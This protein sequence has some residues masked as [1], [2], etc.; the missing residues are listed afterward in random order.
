[1]P[2]SIHSVK[3]QGFELKVGRLCNP[4]SVELARWPLEVVKEL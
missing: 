3:P 1:L 4:F 2:K